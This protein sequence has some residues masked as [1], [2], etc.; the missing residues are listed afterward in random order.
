MD[1]FLS[2]ALLLLA[3]AFTYG[4]YSVFVAFRD[5]WNS[6]Q[7]PEWDKPDKMFIF[8]PSHLAVQFENEYAKIR[9][10]ESPLKDTEVKDLGVKLINRAILDLQAL[11][12]VNSIH[13]ASKSLY[14]RR[15]I[16]EEEWKQ[17]NEMKKRADFE[18]QQVM[19]RARELKFKENIFQTAMKIEAHQ[20]QQYMRK[21]HAEAQKRRKQQMQAA[22]AALQKSKLDPHASERCETSRQSGQTFEGIRKGFLEKPIP[23]RRKA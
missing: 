18:F 9:Q 16:D 14:G 21:M 15:K 8:R 20:R 12:R 19:Q 22:K 2:A 17:V 13:A 5:L 1:T 6:K 11:R 10:R 7:R 23:R 3:V 4:A